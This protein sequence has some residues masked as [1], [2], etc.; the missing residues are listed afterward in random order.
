MKKSNIIIVALFVVGL[1][2]FG[3]IIGMIFLSNPTNN[4]DPGNSD[5]DYDKKK[6]SEVHNITLIVD[7][8]GE[9]EPNEKYENISLYNNK[10]T[11]FDALN[12]SCQIKYDHYGWGLYITEING[13]G[14]GW[15]YTV[16]N[17]PM[18]PIPAN[19]YNLRDNDV[20]KWTHV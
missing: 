2:V 3:I 16:N 15:T 1:L 13:V 20:I 12:K 11:V 5:Q 9:K 18:P 7:Y 8:S 14:E 6:L 4:Y 17:E 10:T 19:K